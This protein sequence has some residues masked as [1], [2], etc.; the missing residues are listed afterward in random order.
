VFVGHESQVAQ[1]HDYLTGWIGRQP[2]VVMRAGDGQLGCFINSCPHKGARLALSAR[3]N[4]RAHLCRYHGWSFDSAGRIISVRDRE[5]AAYPQAF[6]TLSQD[7]VP[8][9]RFES[10]RGFLFAS[11]NPQVTPLSQYL[12]DARVFIDLVIDQ[13][14]QGLELIPGEV[15]YTFRANW[16]LQIEN[17]VDAYHFAATHPSYLKLLEIR[18]KA[19]RRGPAT[20][21]IWQGDEGGE[22][23][24]GMGAFGFAQ[25]HALAWTHSPVRNHPLYPR[26][27]SLAQRVGRVRAQWMMRTRQL[28]IFPNMQIGS[29]AAI[30][31]RVIRPVAVNLTEMTTYCVV[32]AG[33]DAPTRYQ[34]LRQYE[35]FYN[36]TGM[37]T[38]DD[39]INY[40]SCQRGL[41]AGQIE[42]QQGYFRGMRAVR[43]GADEHARELGILPTSSMSGPFD[44]A[45]ETIFHPIYRA[46]R[47][48][49]SQ[50]PQT[51]ADRAYPPQ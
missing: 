37:A 11:L 9:A 39:T 2:I 19:P 30:Q 50:A 15:R 20:R 21:S 44:L 26:L 27:E 34:R 29:S 3:G 32:P 18:A 16:K 35:E 43:P 33:E 48:R 47:A 36:P 23:E 17:T 24:S 12:G 45:D 46:W 4:R 38:P 42:W 41:E 25:G 6:D 10:Y 1:P 22:L 5:Q 51:R 13:S 40:E 28:N 31:L 49:M 8:V 7:L 14:E